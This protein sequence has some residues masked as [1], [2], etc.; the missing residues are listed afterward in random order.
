VFFPSKGVR[1]EAFSGTSSLLLL[2]M[3]RFFSYH[4]THVIITNKPRTNNNIYDIRF[5]SR[6]ISYL[7]FFSLL[8]LFPLNFL[9]FVSYHDL[10][11]RHLATVNRWLLPHSP[12]T[13]LSTRITIWTRRRL[14]SVYHYLTF[15]V[16]L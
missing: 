13:Y 14:S 8:F 4:L 10:M 11:L 1:V 15:Y 6:L 16:S 7:N 2:R 5:P 3:G 9:S 12:P